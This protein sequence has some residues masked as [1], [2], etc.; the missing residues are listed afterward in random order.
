MRDHEPASE[1]VQTAAET[2]RLADFETHA[3]TRVSWRELR[4]DPR[5]VRLPRPHTGAETRRSRRGQPG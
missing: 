5:E 1:G 2:F 4:V 3:G